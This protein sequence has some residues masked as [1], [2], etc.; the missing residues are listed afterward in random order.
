MAS[1]DCSGGCTLS[2]RRPDHACSGFT[3]VPGA[4]CAAAATH[5]ATNSAATLRHEQRQ[6]Q[7]R[8]EPE[9]HCDDGD[10]GVETQLP[11]QQEEHA[12]QQVNHTHGLEV[13]ETEAK[14]TVMQVVLVSGER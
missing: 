12:L 1:E 6:Q 5:A 4:P 10:V 14:Q 13:L 3:V 8:R 9:E 7:R 11:R 2:G